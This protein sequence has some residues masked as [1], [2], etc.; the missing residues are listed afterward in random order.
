MKHVK[1]L[2]YNS[3]NKVFFLKCERVLEMKYV[4]EVVHHQVAKEKLPVLQM[5]LDYELLTLYDAMK[6]K[7]DMEIKESKNRLKRLRL[8]WLQYKYA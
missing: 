3:K 8:K 1:E 4:M 2:T 7:N 6:E 5:E